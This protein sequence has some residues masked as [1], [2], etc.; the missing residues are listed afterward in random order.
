[1]TIGDLM[2][3]PEASQVL[4]EFLQKSSQTGEPFEQ[5]EPRNDEMILAMMRYL[6]LRGLINFGRGL[7]TE[8]MLKKI[9]EKVNKE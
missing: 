6:P 2:E 4:K 3:D 1:S 9:L 7:F 8:E 5:D